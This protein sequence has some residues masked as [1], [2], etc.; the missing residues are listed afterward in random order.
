MT[1]LPKL[2][3]Q[4]LSYLEGP[5]GY[6]T[7]RGKDVQ[8]V[9]LEVLSSSVTGTVNG[10]ATSSYIGNIVYW[11]PMVGTTLNAQSYNLMSPGSQTISWTGTPTPNDSTIGFNGSNQYGLITT[12][13]SQLPSSLSFSFW[14]NFT[15][16]PTTGNF[17]GMFGYDA[18]VGNSSYCVPIVY[19][20]GTTYWY[21][22]Y[23]GNN[24]VITG[25]HT[26]TNS[27]WYHFV[28]TWD[29][30]AHTVHGYINGVSDGSA[31]NTS[32][33]L[34]FASTGNLEFGCDINGGLTARIIN[35]QITDCMVFNTVLTTTQITNLYNTQK[36][37]R[38][39]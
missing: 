23:A 10:N 19:S 20:S 2:A 34:P 16:L 28:L 25:S 32:V 14:A 15:A 13:A 6:N 1:Q 38:G 24:A 12:T 8:N 7:M 26:L 11:W 27:T 21:V 31:T 37:I 39:F 3:Q 4:Y 5:A 29:G 33:T 17:A 9:H 18:G 22:G 30:T 35:G 36:A